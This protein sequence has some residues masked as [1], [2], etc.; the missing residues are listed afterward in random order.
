MYER[1]VEQQGASHKSARDRPVHKYDVILQD[2][3]GSGK[4]LAYLLP[5]LS[6]IDA[7]K[8]KIQ[9]VVML[10]TRELALQVK[11]TDTHSCNC[12]YTNIHTYTY[13]YIYT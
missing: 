4:T 13:T 1:Y 11:Y 7:T 9:A 12:T 8:K 5:L 10:P 2:M 3:T 6:E